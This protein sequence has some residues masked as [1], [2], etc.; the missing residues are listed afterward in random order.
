ML[1]Y[2]IYFCEAH[3][4]RVPD[5]LLWDRLDEIRV[6]IVVF[7]EFR[8]DGQSQEAAFPDVKDVHVGE[9]RGLG[10]G[11]YHDLPVLKLVVKTSSVG[12]ESQ[13]Y[14]KASP[15]NKGGRHSNVG[16]LSG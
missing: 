1:P 14:G 2:A 8:I 6:D 13:C 3:E 4:H 11:K 5:I 9:H 16:H 15:R 12:S 10:L 7:L